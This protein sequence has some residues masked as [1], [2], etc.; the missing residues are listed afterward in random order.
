MLKSIIVMKNKIF[1]LANLQDSS[2]QIVRI[3]LAT[4]RNYKSSRF[5]TLD[6]SYK[7]LD[8]IPLPKFLWVCE[9]TNEKLY[10]QGRA[11]AEIVLDATASKN[12]K[13]NQIILLR[14]P[15][16]LA[17]KIFDEDIEVLKKRITKSYSNLEK[18]F[19]MFTNNLK[20]IER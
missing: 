2:Q 7:I 18:N 4:A 11:Y 16:K 1:G 5:N 17:W 9:I 3:F 20:E 14:Y 8:N 15:N 6:K 10:A 19:D 13:L 12:D